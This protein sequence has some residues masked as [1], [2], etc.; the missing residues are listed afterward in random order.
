[1]R[2]PEKT[3]IRSIDLKVKDLKASLTFYSEMLVF[4]I[5]K[6]ESRNVLL[7][8]DGELPYLISLTE[9]K[10]AAAGKKDSA[11]LFHVAFRFRNRKELA[12]VFLRLFNSGT[13]F[14]GFS[15]HLVSEA[16]YLSDPDNNGVELYTDK[17]KSEW[18][19]KSGQ[20]MM[21]TLPLD[22][23][24]ITAELD[25]PDE[26]NGIDSET[27][28]GHIHLSVSDLYQA[29]KF[30]GNILGFDVSNSVYSGALFFAAGGYHHHIGT[31]IWHSRNKKVSS[32]NQTGLMSF[33]IK[34]PDK[35]VIQKIADEAEESKLTV[36]KINSGEITIKD[37]DGISVRIAEQ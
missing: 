30:Y 3:K 36:D 22:L 15:D 23:S 34:I 21:D 4:K 13:K 9:D 12:R 14:Q 37:F 19:I 18:E 31:N 1:M 25:N 16:I 2:I 29:E 11:G 10:T 24:K 8:A 32:E 26:W 5:I 27:D 20:V 35:N 6:N 17:P 33:T 28:I 7:S